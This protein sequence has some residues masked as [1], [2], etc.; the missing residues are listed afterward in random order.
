MRDQLLISSGA[1]FVHKYLTHQWASSLPNY[2]RTQC[3]SSQ[4]RTTRSRKSSDAPSRTVARRCA[5]TQRLGDERP[6]PVAVLVSLDEVKFRF[7][8]HRHNT[9]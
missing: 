7:P 4:V 3:L 8:T 9:S 1:W 2:E 5:R 6:Q